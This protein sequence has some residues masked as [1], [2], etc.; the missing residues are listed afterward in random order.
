MI[1]M[2]PFSR[3]CPWDACNFFVKR[4]EK[5]TDNRTSQC[6]ATATD[7][8]DPKARAIGRIWLRRVIS[9]RAGASDHFDESP[10]F[11]GSH[12]RHSS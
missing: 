5:P 10:K 3:I 9:A 12:L 8:L 2:I 6:S 11:T 7:T 1:G 4:V